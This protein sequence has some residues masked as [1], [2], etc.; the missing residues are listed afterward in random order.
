MARANYPMNL[1]G[2]NNLRDLGGYPTLD[3]KT[4]RWNQFL[5]GDNPGTLSPYDCQTLYSYGVRLQLDLR[6]AGEVQ[7]HPSPLKGFRDVAYHNIQL[8]D[9]I[10]SNDGSIPMP[11]FMS[12]VY[13]R[14]L[15]HSGG[16]FAAM[17]RLMLEYP[18]D[19]VFFNCTAGKDRT[20]TTAMLL[21]K[22]A[23][24]GDDVI[25]ADYAATYQ[26]IRRDVEAAT[27]LYLE[28]GIEI[29]PALL[30][31]DAEEMERTLAHFQKTYGTIERWLAGIGLAPVEIAALRRKLVG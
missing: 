7:R 29:A 31:S 28:K 11:T 4:T 16:H 15:D 12:Q 17:F 3:G 22:T 18:E 23:H 19:C 14:L 10:Q 2:P 20:G 27:K 1:D 5:R 21:L 26:N 25:I 30:R 9:D 24:C 8:L 13:I 6:S